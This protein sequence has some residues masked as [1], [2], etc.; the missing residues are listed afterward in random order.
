VRYSI[1]ARSGYMSCTVVGR[2]NADDMREFLHAVQAACRQHAC[3]RIL[4]SVRAS[5]VIFKPDDYGLSSYVPELLSPHCQIALLGDS[6]ELQVAHEYIELVARQK[7]INTRAFRD[8]PAALAWLLAAPENG[9]A[10]PQVELN[11]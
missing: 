3:P 6:Q 1:E 9:G 10:A 11:R 7:R 2:E 4:M 5:R 8:E